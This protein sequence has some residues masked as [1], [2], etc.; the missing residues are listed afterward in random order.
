MR[1]THRFWLTLTQW[2]LLT[3]CSGHLPLDVNGSAPD[4]DKLPVEFAGSGAAGRG[5]RAGEGVAGGSP[6]TMPGRS[7]AGGP[8]LPQPA[9]VC[10]NGKIE[11]PG[12]SCERNN[13]QGASCQSLGYNGGGVLLCNPATCTF[14]TLMCRMTPGIGPDW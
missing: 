11:A 2:A 8:A 10:G 7:G 4:H 12:E 5:V 9:S 13:L 6:R 14:D 1:S 3:G